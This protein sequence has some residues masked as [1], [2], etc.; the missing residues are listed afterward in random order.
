[1]ACTVGTSSSRA[2]RTDTTLIRIPCCV[3][4]AALG[5]R[6]PGLSGRNGQAFDHFRA[7]QEV[8]QHAGDVGEVIDADQIA[9]FVEADQVTYPGEGGD[10]GDAVRVAQNP[11]AALQALVKHTKQA[12]AFGYVAVA[13]TLVFVVLAGKFVEEAELAEHRPDA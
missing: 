2:S 13:R 10:I 12:F 7:L 11:L 3:R 4:W 9:C 5:L 8:F 6:T 1:M